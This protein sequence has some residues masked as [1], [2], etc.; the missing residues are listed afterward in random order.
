[1][2][3]NADGQMSFFAPDSLSGKTCREQRVPTVARTSKSSSRNSSESQTQMRPLCLCLIREDG[4]KPDA[5]MTYW[6]NSPLLGG[7]AMHSFGDRKSVV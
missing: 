4:L 3:E 6:E 1:M 7:F 5:S 2:T